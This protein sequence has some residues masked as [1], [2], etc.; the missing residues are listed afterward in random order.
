M[1]ITVQGGPLL[2]YSLVA[3]QDAM[4]QYSPHP[5]AGE[6]SGIAL[7]MFRQPSYPSLFRSNDERSRLNFSYRWWEDEA[8]TIL[9]SFDVEEIKR[10]IRYGLFPDEQLPRMALQTRSAGAVDS[11]LA[12]LV[13]P[14]EMVLLANLS[15]VQKV[16]EIIQRC[17]TTSPPLI[18]WGWL[19]TRIHSELDPPAIAQAIDTESH[20]HFARI[21][22]EEL[23]RHA[24]GYRSGRV[25]WF[26][27]QHMVFYTHLLD[28]L[29]AYPQ[30]LIR[31]ADVEKHLR[32]Q[33]PFAHRAVAHALQGAGLRIEPPNAA[34]GFEFFASPIQRVFRD[35]PPSLVPIL[36]ALCVLGIRFERT[37]LH[38]RGMNWSQEF[39][40]AFSFLEDILRST[41]STDFARILTC[42]DERDFAELAEEEAF[43]KILANRLSIRWELLSID[44]WECCR[45]LPDMIEYIQECLQ[46]LLALRNYHSLT[47]ILSGLHKYSVS[48]STS[49]HT[50][51]GN[52]ALALDPVF[53]PELEYLL[54]PFQNYTAYRH[55]YQQ[56]PGI[57]FLI[58]HLNE[59]RQRGEPV[60]QYLL[61]QL[62]AVTH[63]R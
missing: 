2:T 26:L 39:T 22:F 33:S 63:Q 55:Q 7:Y 27:Q 5:L 13:T 56:A 47:A 19:P 29:N 8:A 61:A 42:T 6:S 36:K 37:Y 16:E 43:D 44:V 4:S 45:A 31:Y 46:P 57:P 48:E 62:K 23:V 41:S 18:S 20:L 10:V 15:H 59:Y 24:L 35:L 11:F 50:G 1:A 49:V 58:P 21:S 60:L 32:N 54:E 12:G 53:P 34:L 28:F 3:S 9:W 17:K 14:Q 30:E 51:N 25:E 40:I 38:S 52:T